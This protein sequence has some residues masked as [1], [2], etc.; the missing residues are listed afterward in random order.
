[1]LDAR[2]FSSIK[3]AEQLYE[4]PRLNLFWDVK[5]DLI[6]VAFKPSGNPRFAVRLNVLYYED[7]ITKREQIKRIAENI[8]E[9]LARARR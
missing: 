1:M 6:D 5:H 4:N 3:V 9:E 8:R 2:R 7:G